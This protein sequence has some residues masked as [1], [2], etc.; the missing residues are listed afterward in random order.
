[1]L[2]LLLFIAP[3]VFTKDKIYKMEIYGDCYYYHLPSEKIC[4]YKYFWNY[5]DIAFWTEFFTIKEKESGRIKYNVR[6]VWC[7][8]YYG[9]G[10]VVKLY[11]YMTPEDIKLCNQKPEPQYDIR[12]N[13][14]GGR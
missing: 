8:R 10:E 3:T 14:K 2:V 12:V 1:M 9:G 6:Y 7:R 5:G 13:V 4:G 11:I